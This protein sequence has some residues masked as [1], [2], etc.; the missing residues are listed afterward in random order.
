MCF[1]LR[2]SGT[3]AGNLCVTRVFAST[4]VF[5]FG[6]APVFPVP[7]LLFPVVST[8]R[9]AGICFDVSCE[10]KGGSPPWGVFSLHIAARAV[11]VA[12]FDTAP[13]TRRWTP[14]LPGRIAALW[15]EVTANGLAPLEHGAG[16]VLAGTSL[17]E[18]GVERIVLDADRLVRGHGAVGLD[19]VLKA[20]QLPA[21]ISDLDAGLANVF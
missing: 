1:R 19:T 5:G 20:E 6:F 8:L 11:G 2:Q 12:S 9:G 18:E 7:V 17:R 21:R 14:R 13:T 15:Q 10:K 4:P 3:K 16:D